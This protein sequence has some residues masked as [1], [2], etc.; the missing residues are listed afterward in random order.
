[1]EL[2]PKESPIKNKKKQLAIALLF[3]CFALM[4]NKFYLENRLGEFKLEQVKILVAANDITS[5]D[6]LVAKTVQVKEVPRAYVPKAAIGQSAFDSYRGLRLA[7]DVRK[8]DYVLEN[9]FATRSAVGNVLSEQIEGD[10]FRAMTIPVDE[11]NSLGRSVVSGD[12]VDILYSFDVPEIRRTVS[13]LLLQDISVVATGAYSVAEQ[14][15][16]PR[17][18][19]ARNFSTITLRLPAQDAVRLNYARQTG[20]ISLMLRN[21]K[22]NAPLA[23]TPISGIADILAS[24]DQ[25]RLQLLT[26]SDTRLQSIEQSKEA[27][28]QL[29]RQQQLQYGQK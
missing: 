4:G 23:I 9:Y 19:R 16:G 15:L 13:V 8:G 7:V 10:N 17:G 20:K 21:S 27:M 18:A 1:M 3:G 6:V 28:E 26:E 22:D 2:T 24:D 29:I 25:Q 11:L 12:H 14:E 5:G